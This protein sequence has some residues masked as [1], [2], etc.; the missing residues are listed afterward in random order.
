MIIAANSKEEALKQC[1]EQAEAKASEL[2]AKLGE[3]VLYYVFYIGKEEDGFDFAVAYMKEPNRGAK[4]SAMDLIYGMQATRA[5]DNIWY[6]CRVQEAS[7]E[8]IEKDDNLYL[9]LISS[10]IE[11]IKFMG[12]A[13]KK[14]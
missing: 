4:M 7:D 9:G 5:A 1:E 3:N 8:R 11:E 13:L 2:Q 10:I 12:V 6:A 14:K